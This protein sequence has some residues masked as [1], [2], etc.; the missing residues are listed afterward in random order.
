MN[1]HPPDDENEMPR[2][3]FAVELAI[4]VFLGICVVLAALSMVLMFFPTR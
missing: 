4:N 1:T 2:G 3:E